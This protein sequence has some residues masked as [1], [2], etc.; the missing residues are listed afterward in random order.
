MM[1]TEPIY[2]PPS[3]AKYVYGYLTS[4]VGFIL[5]VI[6]LYYVL[7]GRGERIDFGWFLRYGFIYFPSVTYLVG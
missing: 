5:T 7:T 6:V 1:S 4:L 2:S 3:Y